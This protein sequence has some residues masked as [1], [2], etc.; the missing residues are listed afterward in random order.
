MCQGVLSAKS[1]QILD[2]LEI[3]NDRDYS[4]QMGIGGIIRIIFPTLF[5]HFILRMSED[6]RQLK[7]G[8]D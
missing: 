5:Y 7:S 3:I 4:Q 6:F 2:Y 1:V 8:D